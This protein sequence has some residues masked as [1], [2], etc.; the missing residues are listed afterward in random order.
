MAE[1][2]LESMGRLHTTKPLMNDRKVE[3]KNLV[4]GV[5]V[6]FGFTVSVTSP[7]SK[8]VNVT[9]GLAVGPDGKEFT[10]AIDPTVDGDEYRQALKNDSAVFDAEA[11]LAG[12]ASVDPSTHAL[13]FTLDAATET[14]KVHKITLAEK[15]SIEG[16]I[17]G[18]GDAV[19]EFKDATADHAAR[20]KTSA[21]NPETFASQDAATEYVLA[22]ATLAAVGG[23]IN[24]VTVAREYRQPWADMVL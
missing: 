15:T 16:A 5:G 13:L 19:P 2:F 3:F 23:N 21:K 9:R 10:V 14:I 4:N 22:T 12:Y 24:A 18:S 8:K 1:K 11:N 6:V 7:V 17:T 20:G